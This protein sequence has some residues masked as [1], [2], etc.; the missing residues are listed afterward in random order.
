VSLDLSLGAFCREASASAA[1]VE[2]KMNIEAMTIEQLV[3]LRN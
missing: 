3:D 1:L 2:V